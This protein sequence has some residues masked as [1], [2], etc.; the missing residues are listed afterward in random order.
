MPLIFPPFPSFPV[1]PLAFPFYLE[2]AFFPLPLF[3]PF[4]LFASDTGLKREKIEKKRKRKSLFVWKRWLFPARF[5]GLLLAAAVPAEERETAKVL[6]VQQGAE[7]GRR[8]TLA[9]LE[10]GGVRNFYCR[11]FVGGGGKEAE[12]DIGHYTTHTNE[13]TEEEGKGGEGT[14]FLSPE[15]DC[16]R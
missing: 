4:P 13:R 11:V 6:P 1:S 15:K 9:G 8:G 10:N 3:S 5:F 7:G 2:V 12:A 14:L 16:W